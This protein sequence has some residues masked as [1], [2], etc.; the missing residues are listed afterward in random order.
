M[1]KT[2]FYTKGFALGLALKLRRNAT[3]KL[4]IHMKLRQWKITRVTGFDTEINTRINR[5]PK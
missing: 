5:V 2:N 1:N 4:L 3:R